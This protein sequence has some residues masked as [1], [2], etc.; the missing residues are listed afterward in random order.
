MKILKVKH[1]RYNLDNITSIGT[2]VDKEVEISIVYLWVNTDCHRLI[3]FPDHD[4]ARIYQNFVDA[5]IDEMLQSE[6]NSF[7]IRTL[8][9]RAMELTMEII[10]GSD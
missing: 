2:S 1:V 4:E 10:C 8:T 7:D 9:G 3:D 5:E 6:Q